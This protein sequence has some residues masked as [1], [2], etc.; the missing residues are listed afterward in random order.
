MRRWRGLAVLGLA[1]QVAV[2]CCGCGR[3]DRGA[4]LT[5]QTLA[6]PGSTEYKVLEAL[7]AEFNGKHP[8]TRVNLVGERQ[9]L[10]YLVR[11]IIAR[12][13]ADV[14]D[15]RADEVRF[16]AQRGAL[17][18]LTAPCGGA[19]A[20]SHPLAWELGEMELR[21]YAL[22]WA[23]R[24]KLLLYNKA[25]F[26]AV[27]LPDD[28]PPRTWDELAWAAERLTRDRDGDGRPEQFGFA[29]AGK[30]SVDLGRHFATFLSELGTPPVE[31]SDGRWAFTL[32]RREGRAVME[33][34]LRLQRFA[35]PESVVTD[36]A[37][38]LE[39]FRAGRA[40]MVIAGPEGLSGAPGARE[41]IGIGVARVPVPPE[42]RSRCDV[43]FRY[44]AVPGFVMGA[45]R[46][47]AI[48]FVKFLA[49]REA[50]AGVARGL[51]GSTPLIPVRKEFLRPGL[52]EE[53]P[54]LRVFR[55]ALS[56]AAFVPPS[57]VWEGK[58]SKDWIGGIHSLLLGDSRGVRE[59]M[60]VTETTG[61]QALSCLFTDVGHPSA[62][63]TL[64][65]CVLGVL[66][67]IAVAYGVSRH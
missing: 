7:T 64:G 25:A 11:S 42:G 22:P 2:V 13:A 17:V 37:A 40:A 65:M 19:K 45:R 1:A 58:C 26:R 53:R 56:D 23:A 36:D 48:E 49:G 44:V 52:A 31:L 30:R 27:G 5:F 39:Q 67:F 63:M 50:Q 9:R 3:S 24:P 60:V 55:A 66:I 61:N 29:L 28:V 16:L 35:P 41:T 38:A 54:G 47:A 43:V 14:V 32:D 21:A 6:R 59:V 57:F 18:E 46:E 20:E 62:T 10:E 8:E 12:E 51:D 4:G 33:L 15:L 34:L